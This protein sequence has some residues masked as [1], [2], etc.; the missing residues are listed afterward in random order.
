[1]QY[2]ETTDT[3]YLPHE[4]R[5]ELQAYLNA[6][7]SMVLQQVARK[8]PANPTRVDGGENGSVE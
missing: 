8:E 1:M 5:Q 6:W 2:E 3:I 4:N 7:Y